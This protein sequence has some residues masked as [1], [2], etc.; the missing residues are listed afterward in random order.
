MTYVAAQRAAY[1]PGRTSLKSASRRA[2]L[3]AGECLMVAQVRPGDVRPLQQLDAL[4]LSPLPPL[5]DGS[6][7]PLTHRPTFPGRDDPVLEAA[8]AVPPL[9]HH[10]RPVGTAFPEGQGRDSRQPPCTRGPWQPL[11]RRQTLR[12]HRHTASDRKP[13]IAESL[14]G[15]W[16]VEAERGRGTVTSDAAQAVGVQQPVRTAVLPPFP[17][18]SQKSHAM[19]SKDL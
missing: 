1:G 16:L 12:R 4:A 7:Q 19:A 14:F 17:V 3:M 10:W 5:L 9:L 18:T 11:G 2:G 13:G 15:V 6:F 8:S